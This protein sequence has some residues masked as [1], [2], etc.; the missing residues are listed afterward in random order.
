MNNIYR[1]KGAQGWGFCM[2]TVSVY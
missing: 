1:G 2:I